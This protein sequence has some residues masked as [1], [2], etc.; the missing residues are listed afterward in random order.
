MAGVSLT[1]DGWTLNATVSY[2]TH[3]AH[4]VTPDWKLETAVLETGKFSGSHTAKALASY[5]KATVERFGISANRV[6]CVTHN[7][8]AN[9]I[10]A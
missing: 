5:T 8:A 7:K 3:T 4:L 9:Q 6:K 1:T 2:V 10:V